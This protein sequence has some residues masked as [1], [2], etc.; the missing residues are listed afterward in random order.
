MT[1]HPGQKEIEQLVYRELANE[2]MTAEDMELKKHIMNCEK[3]RP[4][5]GVYY[6]LTDIINGDIMKD[7]ME[8]MEPDYGITGAVLA[9][10][11]RASFQIDYDGEGKSGT[12]KPSR[13]NES[14]GRHFSSR[15]R[16]DKGQTLCVDPDKD[17]LCA[18]FDYKR[19]QVEIQVRPKDIGETNMKAVLENQKGERVE[20]EL[21][22]HVIGD[23][24]T[25]VFDH[26]CPGK[27]NVYLVSG[28]KDMKKG[29]EEKTGE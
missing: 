22:Y 29:S 28:E 20:K 21:E 10:N 3:C 5:Y 12:L 4:Y 11:I 24:Y 17:D 6:A 26:V 2:P 23:V 15:V 8:E 14:L 7:W 13:I 27:S 16:E 1:M 19:G 18:A 9:E 25:A